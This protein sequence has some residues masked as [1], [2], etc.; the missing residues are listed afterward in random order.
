MKRRFAYTV[1][2]SRVSDGRCEWYNNVHFQT[3]AFVFMTKGFFCSIHVGQNIFP[4]CFLTTLNKHQAA[5]NTL[6]SFAD[7][8]TYEKVP[9]S[10]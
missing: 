8:F 7:I 6:P 9:S 2:K 4:T 3:G 10:F 5:R 1:L